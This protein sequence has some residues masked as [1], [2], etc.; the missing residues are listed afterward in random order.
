MTPSAGSLLAFIFL[1]ASASAHA[2]E[3]VEHFEGEPAQTLTEA[4]DNLSTYNARL[5]TIVDQESLSSQDL[6]EVHRLT[7]TLENALG[8]L[9]EEMNDLAETLETVHLASERAQP[10]TVKTAGREYLETARKIVD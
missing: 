9:R 2:D 8:K 3:R 5:A 6:L 7:Y 1:F 10:D 4:L